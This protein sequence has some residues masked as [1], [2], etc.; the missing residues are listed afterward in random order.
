MTKALQYPLIRKRR[1]AHLMG[2]RELAA[3]I[4]VSRQALSDYE[5]GKYPPTDEVFAKLKKALRLEGTVIDYFGRAGKKIKNQRY[6]MDS[7]CKIDGCD[8]IPVCKDMCMKHYCKHRK[9]KK[10]RA[11]S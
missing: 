4:G 11:K 6:S 3:K 1:Q 8:A 5:N 9:L 7:K 2:I 10:E